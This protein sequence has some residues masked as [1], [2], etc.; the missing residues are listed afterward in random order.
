MWEQFRGYSS[1]STWERVLAALLSGA[2]RRSS[3]RANDVCWSHDGRPSPSAPRTD[4]Q[5]G[6]E[7]PPRAVWQHPR[8]LGQHYSATVRKPMFPLAES[9]VFALRAATRYLLQYDAWQRW[10]PPRM[11][12]PLPTLG[13]R[14]FIGGEFR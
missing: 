10:E 3:R 14:G 2:K 4:R 8:S 11:T 7:G 5:Y 1:D 9:G 12:R 13:P 6:N